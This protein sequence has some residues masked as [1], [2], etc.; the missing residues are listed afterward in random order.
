MKQL[1][2]ILVEDDPLISTDLVRQLAVQNVDT[3]A[4]YDSSKWLS[5]NRSSDAVDLIITNMKLS[6]GWTDQLYFDQIQKKAKPLMILTGLADSVYRPKIDASCQHTY[7]FKPFNVVNI[8]RAL[9]K[10]NLP[11][12]ASQ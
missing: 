12:N 1:K 2:A 3:V 6:N 11:D 5:E 4:V 7:C 10:L 9:S 8:R